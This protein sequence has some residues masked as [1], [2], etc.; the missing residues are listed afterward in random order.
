MAYSSVLG[1][2]AAC[3]WDQDG[4][5]Y[6]IT[7]DMR[8]RVNERIYRIVQK[9][10]GWTDEICRAELRARYD[11]FHSGT[12]ALKDLGFP[13]GTVERALEEAGIVDFLQRDEKL[14]S[15]FHRLRDLRHILATGS[16]REPTLRKLERLGLYPDVFELM[17]T[18]DDM[19]EPKPHNGWFTKPVEYTG[20][21][22]Q[23]LVWIDDRPDHL[24]VARAAGYRTILVGGDNHDTEGDVDLWVPEVY[25]VER[26]LVG[27]R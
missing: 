6:K 22:P 7:E 16:S 2:T 17:I 10:Y 24:L 12:L 8:S 3:V 23:E 4:T 27:A 19:D 26:Y 15:M 20:L 5:L 13:E 11:R 25:E 21:P 14:V 18:A 9:R 1:I